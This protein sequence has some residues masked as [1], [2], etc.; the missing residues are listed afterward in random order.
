M[1]SNK[2]LT[3]GIPA[4]NIENYISRCLDSV[5]KS[6]YLDMLDIIV[7]DDGSTDKTGEIIDQYKEKYPEINVIHKENGGWGTA[8]NTAIYNAKGKYF[9]NLDSDDWF[10]T[11]NLNAFILDIQQRDEDVIFTNF[12]EKGI[13]SEKINTL[14]SKVPT[15]QTVPLK[16]FLCFNKFKTYPIHA[17]C[18]KTKL[19]TE[20]RYECVPRYY[21]D[22][23]YI[24]TPFN[25]ISTI[26]QL[27]YNIYRYFIGRE[28]QSIQLESYWKNY[29]DLVEV[30]K[31]IILTSKIKKNVFAKK[32]IYKGAKSTLLWTYYVTLVMPKNNLNYNNNIK[33]L[34][35]FDKWIKEYNYN[36]YIRSM[37]FSR[38]HIPFIAI[39]RLFRINLFDLKNKRSMCEKS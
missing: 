19:L 28:G 30:C 32:L 12:I 39:W 16:N 15:A 21:G 37:Y 8:I 13:N 18:Y 34:K 25:F 1:K 3:I 24:L 10:D 31:K 9:K 29:K 22:L 7:V 23:D 33:I 36:L 17:I 14:N 5:V 20:N 2:I 6:K 35:N 26:C 11:D 27:D 4:Y 38:K